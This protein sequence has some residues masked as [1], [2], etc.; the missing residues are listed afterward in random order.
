MGKIMRLA[1]IVVV[2]PFLFLT[3]AYIVKLPGKIVSRETGT[4]EPINAYNVREVQLGN[5]LYRDFRNPPMIS[6][7]YTPLYYYLTGSIAR[8]LK[9]DIHGIYVVGRTIAVTCGLLAIWFIFILLWR[10]GAPR[11]LTFVFLIYLICI[12]ATTIHISCDIT[13]DLPAALVSLL[14]IL[15]VYSKREKFLWAAPLFAISI[16]FKQTAIMA[17][18]AVFVWLCLEKKWKNAF[19]FAVLLGI[20]A[21]VPIYLLNLKTEGRLFLNCVTAT[22]GIAS[23]RR[24]AYMI[25]MYPWVWLPIFLGLSN[26]TYE[27]I[28]KRFHLFSIYFIVSLFFTCFFLSSQGTNVNHFLP[29]VYSGMLCVVCQSCLFKNKEW[30]NSVIAIMLLIAL[31]QTPR[32][33]FGVEKVFKM[34]LYRHSPISLERPP[35]PRINEREKLFKIL[36]SNQVLC[37]NDN[38]SLMSPEPLLMD[39]YGIGN[40]TKV[41]ELDLE[42]LLRMIREKKIPLIAVSF[43]PAKVAPPGGPLAYLKYQIAQAMIGNYQLQEELLN[44]KIYGPQK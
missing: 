20:L 40:L 14:G 21:G 3:L 18:A 37:D 15:L 1:A 42:P 19:I 12:Q 32:T 16:F 22:A 33:F 44:I 7:L 11:W 25:Q 5:R 31:T 41:G 34:V 27:I 24:F 4:T 9:L 17:P 13:P 26:L 10:M 6:T 38:L 36:K 8:L 2:L 30:L 39:W 28:Q 43:D 23:N 29:V 35:K